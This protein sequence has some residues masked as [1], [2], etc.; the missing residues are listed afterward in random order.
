MVDITHSD[1]NINY[2]FSD[3]DA[4][5]KREPYEATTITPRITLNDTTALLTPAKQQITT[6]PILSDTIP[7]TSTT[8]SPPPVL[9]ESTT[10]ERQ[11]RGWD[12]ILY[13]LLLLLFPIAFV[14]SLD[15]FFGIPFAVPT[16]QSRDQLFTTCALLMYFFSGLY[17][18]FV[19]QS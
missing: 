16:I 14:S 1:R 10:M 4:L 2:R 19:K 5:L 17:Y 6:P 8:T 11:K 13:T 7:T 3:R 15:L 12:I 18:A 9:I